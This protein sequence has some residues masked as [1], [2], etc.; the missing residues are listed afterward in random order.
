MSLAPRAV[1]VHRRTEYEELLARHGTHGQAAFFLSSRGRSIDEVVRRHA[2]TQQALREVAAAVP[3]TWRGARVER[4]DLDRFLFAP[5][6]VVVVVGQDGLVAN[7]AKYLRGQ[8]VVGIDSDPG[9][10]PGV[11]V[12]HRC[13]DAA[14]LLR[15]ATA[16]GGRAEELTMVEAVAD[17]T[18]RLLALN[19]IYLGSSGHQTVR[20]RLGSAGTQGADEAQASS[21]VLVGTGT[22]ATGWLRSL[23]LERGSSAHLPAPADPRLLW[24]VREAWPSPT[25]GT[26][27]VAGELGRGQALQLT[28]ESDRMV[29]FGDGME[30]DAMQLTWG[31]SI[32]LGIADTS[33]H[34]VT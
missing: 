15:A 19:E 34:L 10:N 16:P 6:D 8:P 30:N 5:E 11:L 24:F 28:V 1:L 4:A 33:L 23:W 12:R 3:L 27:Q 18:Q 32:S 20:Y 9:R 17:D 14:A 26:T 29:V 13:A 2:S 21:G 7:T 31:Q 22:G 25:T